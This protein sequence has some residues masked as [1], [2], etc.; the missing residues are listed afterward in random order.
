MC[1]IAGAVFWHDGPSADE[2]DAIVTRMVEALAHRGPDG[3]G[4]VRCTAGEASPGPRATFG[5]TR[6]S[7]IDLSER[8][9][10]P[11]TTAR[12]PVWI[13]Y[14]GEIYNFAALRAELESLGRA[15]RSDSD[16]E[17]LLQGYEQWG[18]G[19]VDRLHGMFAFA[20]WDGVAR[21]LLLARDRLGIKPLYVHRTDR[22]LLFASEVRS[23]LA[24]GLVERKLDPIALDQ[25]LAYQSVPTPRTLVRHVQM[26]RPA[27]IAI[28]GP[29]GSY[30]ERA[31][32]DLLTDASPDARHATRAEA[33][34]RVHD[35]LTASVRR[36]LV[37]DVPVGV[38]LSGG[39]DSG[40][41]V[42][43]M[44]QA[45]A[46]PRT[47]TIACP[48]T[49]YDEAAE[50]RAV[51]AQF[52]AEH[53]EIPLD[54]AAMCH[55][56]PEALASADHP[57]G[58]GPNTFIV[59]H[60]VRRTGLKVALSGL[61]GDEFFGG[62]PSFQRLGRLAPYAR[63]WRRSPAGVRATAAAAVRTLAGRS[64]A[65][66]KAAALVESDGSLS[67]MFPILR[68]LF[69]VADRSDLLGEDL[70]RTSRAAGDPY[71]ALLA[72]A[73]ARIDGLGELALI[74]YA[75]ARTY[76]HDVLL[77]DT[78][79]MSMRHALEVR[80]PLLDHELVAYLMGLP[81]DVRHGGV[82]PKPLLVD[83]LGEPLPEGCLRPKRGFVLPFREWMRGP[84]REFCE[85][86]L[87]GEGLTGRGF[88]RAPGVHGLWQ[89][90]LAGERRTS[91]SRLWTLVALDAWLDRTGVAW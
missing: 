10:Q 3:R 90:F 31:Y 63:L 18:M 79:Q 2:H 7:I 34:R 14:N 88:V 70:V 26:L 45:G 91:W 25:Y 71:V 5:H 84:L 87:G 39:I 55:E 27:T 44:R 57:S 77:R 41:L 9:R 16:T 11:M 60:A 32:W 53:T 67:Q 58:D 72:D 64:V 76:M 42:A 48:G 4:V 78:D 49:S 59:A 66:G 81:D 54:V 29:G 23:L 69:P 56:L 30:D 22:G 74:C 46:I 37:S 12:R 1:G 85:R 62:Y 24:S 40:A 19:V 28:A 50:A 68:Q 13:T 86:H 17:V 38:F 75:E 52:G 73:E 6:L 8:G 80:V 20:I 43:L 83:S 33:R 36:H 47:F 21:R 51:A 89:S 15:F 35:L 82:T 65:S 61:G